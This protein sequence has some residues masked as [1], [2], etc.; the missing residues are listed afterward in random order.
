MHLQSQPSVSKLTRAVP[1]NSHGSEVTKLIKFELLTQSIRRQAANRQW[2][3]LSVWPRL[4]PEW[5]VKIARKDSVLR[6]IPQTFIIDL[7]VNVNAFLSTI[8]RKTLSILFDENG[9]VA[10]NKEK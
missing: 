7:K 2:T 4:L 1:A 3:W 5:S 8:Y 6:F 9:A 10:Y